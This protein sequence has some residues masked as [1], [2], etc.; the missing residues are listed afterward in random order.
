MYGRKSLF[1]ATI[2]IT[3]VAAR[4]PA[5]ARAIRLTI[6]DEPLTGGLSMMVRLQCSSTLRESVVGLPR[7]HF[8]GGA[9]RN[10][11]GHEKR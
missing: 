5:N 4:A 8:E 7:A 6:N 9:V 10:A 3:S 2:E 11:H 1:Q